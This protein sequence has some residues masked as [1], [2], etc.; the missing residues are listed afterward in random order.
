MPTSGVTETSRMTEH[1]VPPAIYL[2]ANPDAA[3]I[4]A[5][6]QKLA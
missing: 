2:D 3:G 5:L 4:A 6:M 1:V